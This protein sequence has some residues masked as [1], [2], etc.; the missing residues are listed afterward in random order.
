MVPESGLNP[1]EAAAAV[2]GF[3]VAHANFSTGG[4]TV[5]SVVLYF[6]TLPRSFVCPAPGVGGR[7]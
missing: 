7:G 6:F 5:P 2:G 3:H 4:R 1:A